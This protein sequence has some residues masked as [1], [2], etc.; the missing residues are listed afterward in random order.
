MRK[1]IKLLISLLLITFIPGCVENGDTAPGPEP[2]DLEKQEK[3]YT[4]DEEL[5]TED[6]VKTDDDELNTQDDLKADDEDL[7]TE[8]ELNTDDNEIKTLLTDE[9]KNVEALGVLYPYSEREG[10]GYIE[11]R[12]NTAKDKDKIEQIFQ[13]IKGTNAQYYKVNP[14]GEGQQSNPTFIINIYY[15]SGS[16][17]EIASTET[18]EGIYRNTTTKNPSYV[19]G[20]NT[21]L[22]KL[23]GD[24]SELYSP[25]YVKLG[26]DIENMLTGFQNNI[27]DGNKKEVESLITAN[28]TEDDYEN[29]TEGKIQDYGTIIHYQ[30]GDISIKAVN[31]KSSE[32]E[33]TNEFMTFTLVKEEGKMK[34]NKI[35]CITDTIKYILEYKKMEHIP[36]TSKYSF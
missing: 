3:L 30:N 21:E 6:E 17:D 7:N 22:Q 24:G 27:K 29:L 14:A 10:W 33:S 31:R 2:K 34:I 16:M 25:E 32:I 28:I 9:L 19:A 12:Y 1:G 11:V 23:L 15:N 18:G 36:N 26:K 4:N 35:E 13:S 8:D 5:N 20:R